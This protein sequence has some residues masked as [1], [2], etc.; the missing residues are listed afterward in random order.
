MPRSK[1][2]L[3]RNVEM[4]D[5]FNN[6]AEDRELFSK[7]QDTKD[8]LQKKQKERKRKKK[9]GK[10][11]KKIDRKITKLNKRHK[12]LVKAVEASRRKPT[13]GVWDKIF[14]KSAPV[15]VNRAFD[16][17]EASMKNRAKK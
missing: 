16:L 2:Y 8:S 6:D 3:E 14:I 12:K 11:T 4:R 7:L 13:F 17:I 15:A 5:L 9:K 10:K 1:K